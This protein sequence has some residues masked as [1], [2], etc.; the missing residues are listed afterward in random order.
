MARKPWASEGQAC[1]SGAQT[2][3]PLTPIRP[4]GAQRGLAQVGVG[5]APRRRGLLNGRWA[6]EAP[7]DHGDPACHSLLKSPASP[8]PEAAYG[9]VSGPP[10]RPKP[11]VSLPCSGPST[12]R[13]ASDLQSS[14]GSSDGTSQLLSPLPGALSPP[15]SSKARPPH[16]LQGF[17]RMSPLDVALHGS[18][19]SNTRF[20]SFRKHGRASVLCPERAHTQ[21]RLGPGGEVGR[22]RSPQLWGRRGGQLRG[23][24]GP[25]PCGRVCAHGLGS[26][27]DP[28]T[29]TSPGH[30]VFVKAEHPAWGRHG[31]RPACLLLLF[32]RAAS[33]PSPR[34]CLLLPLPPPASA[35][36]TRHPREPPTACRAWALRPGRERP[37]AAPR[38]AQGRQLLG[39]AAD[40]GCVAL[41]GLE[42][43]YPR[44]PGR[45]LAAWPRAKAS[46]SRASVSSLIRTSEACH[47]DWRCWPRTWHAVGGRRHDVLPLSVPEPPIPSP[48][49][50][51]QSA[52]LPR[53]PLAKTLLWLLRKPAPEGLPGCGCS[54]RGTW[55]RRNLRNERMSE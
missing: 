26:Q 54:W 40:S 32:R 53:C 1:S 15:E 14:P 7:S 51:S 6:S 41:G 50:P 12:R 28:G 48:A 49:G 27:Q 3:S 47:Q 34:A 55:L 29:A 11:T 36:R 17:A 21:P 19:K 42:G 16:L 24:R 46:T 18:L 2:P 8:A 13:A 37:H 33:A 30:S 44:Q 22:P 38:L 43:P 45:L 23:S 31:Q 5:P 52:H 35:S 10:F 25:A 9:P 4:R 20:Y 39:K